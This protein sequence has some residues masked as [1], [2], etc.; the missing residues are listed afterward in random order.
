MMMVMW[1]VMMQN[2][3]MMIN[4]MLMLAAD[5]YDDGIVVIGDAKYDD[6]DYSSC[7]DC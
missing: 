4:Q 2:M 1:M 6:G 5:E 3:M 7:D